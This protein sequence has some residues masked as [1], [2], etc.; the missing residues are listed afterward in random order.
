MSFLTQSH[1]VFFGRPLCLT[2]STSHVI[3]RLTQSLSS[4]RSSC[5][6]HLN[7]TF[8]NQMNL[9]ID[10]S[11]QL[12]WLQPCARV[13]RSQITKITFEGKMFIA[14]II[15]NEVGWIVINIPAISMYSRMWLIGVGVGC[16]TCDQWVAGSNPSRPAVECN[17]WQVVNTHVPLSPSSIFIY[18]TKLIKVA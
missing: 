4:F 13:Y 8:T 15:V 5:P 10:F 12:F 11:Y 2:P 9:F 16:W 14:H 6:N 17:P 7:E 18:W 1:Q 3:Q